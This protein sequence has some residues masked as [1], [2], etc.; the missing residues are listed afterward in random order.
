VECIKIL[1]DCEKKL[2]GLRQKHKKYKGTDHLKNLC[3]IALSTALLAGRKSGPLSVCLSSLSEQNTN[4][5]DAR[6]RQQMASINGI[7]V[8]VSIL[9]TASK[10]LVLSRRLYTICRRLCSELK[11]LSAHL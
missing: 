5:S 4:L 6:K 9:I 7:Q 10:F 1:L 3:V 2:T 8:H 11:M